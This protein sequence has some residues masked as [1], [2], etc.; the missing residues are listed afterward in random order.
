MPDNTNAYLVEQ[1]KKRD[2][3]ID[4]L[5]EK[6]E[7]L[8]EV[9]RAREEEKEFKE[10]WSWRQLET[11]KAAEKYPD[12]GP[13][14]D[15]NYDL[16]VPRME[17]RW[18]EN[19]HF[20][21]TRKAIYGIVIEHFLGQIIFIPF[22]STKQ[23]GGLAYSDRMG[24]TIQSKGRLETPFRDGAHLLHDAKALNLPVFV[25]APDHGIYRQVDTTINMRDEF[26][27]NDI[28]TLP[29]FEL[30]QKNA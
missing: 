1:L 6:L 15:T 22:G 24:S 28:K 25:V 19:P 18:T 4:K 23:D 17:L 13:E 7:S 26:T 10:A 21:S 29:G 11:L 2:G 16:P 27:E 3:V 30:D 8:E 9:N 12:E 20:N 14:E 5:K